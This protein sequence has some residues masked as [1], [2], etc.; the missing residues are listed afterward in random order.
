MQK[1]T[2]T[3]RWYL[4]QTNTLS[5]SGI[6]CPLLNQAADGLFQSRGPAAANVRSA[7]REL[8]LM[9]VLLELSDVSK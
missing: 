8:G 7:N 5:V 4:E 2:I 1:T 9:T 6:N 3:R